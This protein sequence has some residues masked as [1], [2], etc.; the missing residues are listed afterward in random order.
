M[1]DKSNLVFINV[2]GEI[3]NSVVADRLVYN[4]GL[5]SADGTTSLQLDLK[6]GNASAG[7][8]GDVLIASGTAS[9]LR[10]SIVLDGN[11]I[12]A[13]N[14]QIINVAEPTA[15]QDAATKNYVDALAEGLKPKEAARVSTT[16][17]LSGTMTADDTPP[18][19]GNRSYNTTT[20]A[21]TWFATQGPTTIDGV[22]LVNGD[23]ILVQSETATS[24]PS[25]GEGRKYNGIYVR[26]SLDVWTRA[27][28][29][30]SVTP[31]NEITGAYVPVQEGTTHQG[32]FFVQSGGVTALDTDNIIFVFF[33]AT[34]TLSAGSG[35]DAASFAA[36]IVAVDLVSLGGLQFNGQEIELDYAATYT[37]DA[38]DSLPLN[39]SEL[40]STTASKGASIVGIQDASAYYAGTNLEAVTNELEAQIGGTT[41]STYSFGEANVLANNDSIYPA[42]NKLDLKWG[43]LAS[44]TTSEG[45]SLVGV[46]DASAYYAGT[47]L[48][49]VTNEL[50]AQI[51]GTTSSTYA[52]SEN[53]VLADNDSIYPAL[54]KLDIKWG[55]LASTTASE[56]ASLV[57]VQD[58]A[59]L[60]TATNVEAALAEVML[61]AESGGAETFTAGT[62]GV[63]VGDL[64]VFSSNNTVNKLDNQAASAS[65]FGFGLA[66][67]TITATNPVDVLHDGKLITG[68]LDGATFAAGDKVYF[69]SAGAGNARFVDISSAPSSAG[70]KLWQVGVAA[71]VTDLVI[72]INFVKKNA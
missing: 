20:L 52:F 67:A 44:A 19:T 41:S 42:L 70:S 55:D 56:G 14:T 64:L 38:A 17:V 61:V 32:K 63:V 22:A 31:I 8:S 15:P 57:G 4:G 33:N 24:G 39:T 66:A 59:G 21:I 37:I 27:E 62:G 6:S 71:N 12:D 18:T 34:S 51:G 23:R 50:E 69:D 9:G 48:E 46:E 28:D 72:D 10:G 3:E 26:T 40:A 16:A 35:I 60:Y 53:N 30:D 43:D 25:A 7:A 1:A 65:E 11:E 29:F 58:A 2:D 45:A 13:N 68:I 49:A 54:N 5:K 36:N 47:N